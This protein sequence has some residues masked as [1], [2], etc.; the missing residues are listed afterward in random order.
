M[1]RWTSLVAIYAAVGL[2]FGGV[3]T[4]LRGGPWLHPEPWFTLPTVTAH[5]YSALL[6]LT[7]GFAG[8]AATSALVKKTTWARTLHEELRPFVSSMPSSGIYLVALFSALGEEMLF[9]SVVQSSTNLWIQA[10]IFG[11]AHQLPGR[12]R[13]TWALWATIMGLCF[14]ALYQ[15]TGSLLGPIVAHATINAMN[16]HFLQSHPSSP[17]EARSLGGILGQ[18]SSL[19]ANAPH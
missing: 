4:Y 6:G 3:A 5:W 12:A 7:L 15:A 1:S 8:V 19:E 17:P 9:R 16:L 2:L 18:H 10:L 11:L 14:G 13:W